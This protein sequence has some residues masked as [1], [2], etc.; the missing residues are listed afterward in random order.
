MKSLL[1]SLA[2]LYLLS[3]CQKI[4]PEK[5]CRRIIQ[6]SGVG[7]VKTLP[8]QVE[9]TIKAGFTRAAMKEAMRETQATMAEVHR[10]T[11]KYIAE[12]AEMKT[13]SISAYK[14]Y[15]WERNSQVFKGFQVSQSV[16]ITLKDI[17]RFED[18]TREI[19]A[20]RITNIENLVFS[21]SKADS[22]LRDMDLLALDDANASAR[23]ISQRAGVRLGKPLHIS[24]SGPVEPSW[25]G[26]NQGYA[27]RAAKMSYIGRTDGVAGFQISPE[28]LV[29]TR[30]AFITYEIE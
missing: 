27:P 17:S 26:E 29:F 12:P 3:G 30:E 21:H 22:I 15:A 7:K 24:N 10:V 20:T 18:F 2:A 25:L 23:K 14:E 9:I 4:P 1:V 19:L 16:D 28:M 8:D 11:R 5:E 6:V 13:G